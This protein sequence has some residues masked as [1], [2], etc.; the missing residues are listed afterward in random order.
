MGARATS[1]G[2]DRDAAGVDPPTG[3][4]ISAN[5]LSDTQENTTMYDFRE[6]GTRLRNWGR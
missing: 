1:R 3:A 5:L 2:H 6:I 4:R